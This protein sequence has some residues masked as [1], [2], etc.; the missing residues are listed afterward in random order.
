MF[1]NAELK[2]LC[3]A[4]NRGPVQQDILNFFGYLFVS[5]TSC[6][7]FSYCQNDSHLRLQITRMQTSFLVFQKVSAHSFWAF[8][9]S[10]NYPVF[11]VELGSEYMFYAFCVCV[12]HSLDFPFSLLH[13]H[14]ADRFPNNIEL[15]CLLSEWSA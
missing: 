4:R 15:A 8:R 11:R 12:S 9:Y 13:I 7:F 10:F 14:C 1:R 3:I 2:F 6:R 5:C